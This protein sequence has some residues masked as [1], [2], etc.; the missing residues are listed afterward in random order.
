MILLGRDLEAVCV[1][2]F[3][4]VIILKDST[5]VITSR[6]GE[7]VRLITLLFRFIT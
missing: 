1:R 3:N 6:E 2:T 7:L 5:I 4:N